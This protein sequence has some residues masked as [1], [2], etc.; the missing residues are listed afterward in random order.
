MIPWLQGEADS[1]AE[2]LNNTQKRQDRKKV[3]PC[4]VPNYIQANPH[5]FNAMDF[6]VWREAVMLTMK[7]QLSTD[8]G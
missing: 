6:K 1:F 5:E 4:G 8:K 3:L 7:P 2:R